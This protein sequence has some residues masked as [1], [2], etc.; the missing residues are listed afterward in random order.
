MESPVGEG[1][2][3]PCEG[4]SSLTLAETW[5]SEGWAVRAC[6]V[7][8][9][10]PADEKQDEVYTEKSKSEVVGEG[11]QQFEIASEVTGSC[12]CKARAVETFA[13]PLQNA[14]MVS[15]QI[16]FGIQFSHSGVC[17][18]AGLPPSL[19]KHTSKSPFL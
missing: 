19:R 11:K 3:W 1:E 10:A 2:Q 12:G 14:A 4:K 18:P 13:G 17:F 15:C 7:W 16:S 8:P 6:P 5:A 9:L